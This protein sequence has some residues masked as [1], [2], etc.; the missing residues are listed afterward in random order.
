MD[1]DDETYKKALTYGKLAAQA[2]NWD[3]QVVA[4]SL[5]KLFFAGIDDIVNQDFD[6]PNYRELDKEKEGDFF[7][8]DSGID[9]TVFQDRVAKDYVVAFRGTEL[10]P[11]GKDWVQDV[12]QTWGKSRQ[13]EKAV[14]K[15]KEVIEKVNLENQKNGTNHQVSL[16]GHSLGGGLATAVALATG[17]EAV[18]FDA[19]GLTDAT[20]ESFGLDPKALEHEDKIININVKGCFVSDPKGNM[21]KFTLSTPGTVS[22]QRG[23]QQYWL[24]SVSERADCRHLPDSWPIVKFYESILAH[25]WHVYTYQLEKKNWVVVDHDDD[26]RDVSTAPGKRTAPK[27]VTPVVASKKQRTTK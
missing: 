5:M 4:K 9:Y 15:I 26:H 17:K 1:M 14:R 18:V 8:F 3:D 19:A 13:Y 11:L 10:V 27:P 21:D 22:K 25:A 20:I 12:L 23:T 16:T 24:E 7:D 6:T 2:Y